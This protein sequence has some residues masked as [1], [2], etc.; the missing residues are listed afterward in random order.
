[1]TCNGKRKGT[2]FVRPML[3]VLP[4]HILPRVALR[5]VNRRNATHQIQ[6]SFWGSH[7]LRLPFWTLLFLPSRLRGALVCLLGHLPSHG[8]VALVSDLPP[9]PFTNDQRLIS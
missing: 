6:R 7:R 8:L 2:A 1:M 9:P 5:D 4:W 3:W